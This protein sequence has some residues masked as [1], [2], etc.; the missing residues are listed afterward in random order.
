[1]FSVNSVSKASWWCYIS[2]NW[3]HAF[4]MGVMV[5]LSISLL[6]LHCCLVHLLFL[7]ALY[8]WVSSLYQNLVRTM[9]IPPLQFGWRTLTRVVT[10][11][12]NSI[13]SIDMD[14]YACS[15][16]RCMPLLFFLFSTLN[17]LQR[18]VSKA[19]RSSW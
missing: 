18:W 19:S 11:W 5:E 1:M 16:G 2:P 15:G 13:G 3:H 6:A 9:G 8:G 12:T 10:I 14:D 17:G 4:I 7:I